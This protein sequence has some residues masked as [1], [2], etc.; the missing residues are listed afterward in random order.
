MVI[1][2]NSIREGFG[3]T[4]AEAQFKR[5]AVVGTQQACGLRS[6]IVHGHSGVLVQGDPDVPT[7]VALAVSA[8]LGDDA[9]RDSCAVNGQKHAVERSLIYTQL[10][11]WLDMLGELVADGAP[12]GGT[13]SVRR[14][15]VEEALE[16]ADA[17]A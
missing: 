2:Q 17:S 14:E 3:L 1:V 4:V 13:V 5:V 7:N 16:D 10:G 8:L 6:Q 12:E 9:L 11:L 15:E